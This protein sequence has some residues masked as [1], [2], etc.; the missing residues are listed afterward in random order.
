MNDLHYYAA[1]SKGVG[2][3][4]TAELNEIGAQNVRQQGTGVSFAGPLEIGYRACLWSRVASRILL[5]IGEFPAPTAEALY[6]G[7]QQTDWQEHLDPE[8]TLAIE[9]VGYS[10]D[11]RNSHFGALKVKDAIVDQFRK[12]C[13]L[14]P[15]IDLERPDLRVH[16]RLD[17]DRVQLSL[18]LAGQSLHRRGYRSGTGPA[19]LKENLAAAILLRAGWPSVA[20]MGGTL[21]DPMCGTGTLP[22]E[23]AW[24]AG[25]CAPGLLRDYFGF[26]GWQ[27]H[28][29]KLW[30]RL[31]EEALA[32]RE[33][34]IAK[35]PEIIGCDMNPRAV[36]QAKA[37]AER[38]GLH[39]VV[40]FEQRAISKT[41]K[42]SNP[43]GLVVVNPP[44]GQ[45]LGEITELGGLYAELG[46]VLKRNFQGWKAAVFTGNPQLGH[47][48]GLRALLDNKLYNG[49]I[50][51]RLLRFEVE[52]GYF[53]PDRIKPP[54]IEN[55]T[56]EAKV[57]DSDSSGTEMLANRLRKNRRIL[58]RWA[59]R[60]N[61]ACYRLYDADLPEYA[62]AVD[63]YQGEQLWVH[64]QEYQ[65]PRSIDQDKARHRREEAL[66]T[67]ADV[68]EIPPEQVFL[69]VRHRQKGH[70]QYEKIEQGGAFCEV[71]EGPCR[72]LVNFANYL[73]TGLFLDH[74]LTRELVAKLAQGRSFLNL[75]S[76]TGVA[77][78]RA[79]MEGAESTTSVDMS[80][81]YLDWAQRNLELNDLHG[82]EL[83]RAD[84]LEWLARKQG[85]RYGVIF[86][87]PP[88]FS[89]SKKMDQDFDVQRDHVELI[90][91][92]VALLEED[93]VLIFSNNYRRFLMDKD[94]LT[95]LNLEDITRQTIPID[96][97][98]R[99]K[100][101]NCWKITRMSS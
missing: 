100:I 33:E 75:F 91:R 77:T 1:A 78:V 101:H 42:L 98:R 54:S 85:A 40:R 37:H 80:Q 53:T 67:I 50:E 23:A 45:R 31:R 20:T 22:I 62:L 56:S 82:H 41:P 68:L 63:L 44:Y 58:G 46:Q 35:L 26:S 94:R 66:V 19:P 95:G 70:S 10:R 57:A 61:I 7:V 39:Q 2:D 13:G 18:D 60:A 64:V 51:C 76:Y 32:R 36:Q 79:A 96:F 47:A 88:T 65:A 17:R 38:A 55:A 59:R 69:K 9:F 14:R 89:N 28:V 16:T 49:P 52:E 92:A 83:V 11:I 84:C 48:L 29:P 3:L 74:R 12:G 24:I 73:D 97:E 43:A 72:L 86:L 93:G 71:R 30:G 81:T 4:L 34:G 15:S 99:P 8:G 5:R 25:D 90:K 6:E 21:M 27:G 87:D